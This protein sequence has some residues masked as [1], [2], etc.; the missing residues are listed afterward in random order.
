MDTKPPKT[1]KTPRKISK[2]YLENAALYYLQRYATSAENLRRV[3]M[4]KVQRSCSFHEMPAEEFAPLVDELVERYKKSGLLDDKSFAHARVTSLRRQGL[5]S[6]AI[7]AKLQVKGL[8]AAEIEAALKI[9]DAESE[10]PELD[11]ARAYAKRKKLGPWRTRPQEPQK[12]LA[13]MGRAGFSYEVAR[14]A[15]AD[16]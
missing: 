5:S 2:T 14:R 9:V 6:R 12:E 11:A 7:A 4:R 3:L 10:E 13:A 15:L 8:P 16:D 1:R